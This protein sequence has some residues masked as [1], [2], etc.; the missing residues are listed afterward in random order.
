M[1]GEHGIGLAKK[2]YLAESIAP[3]IRALMRGV[4]AAFD[5]QGILNPDKVV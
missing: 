4:K 5:P 3:E 1:S 2:P